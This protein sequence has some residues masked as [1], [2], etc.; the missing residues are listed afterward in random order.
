MEERSGISFL[1]FHEELDSAKLKHNSK[2]MLRARFDSTET[3]FGTM[4]RLA[5][6]LC[7]YDMQICEMFH[8][9]YF[10]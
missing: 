5:W 6:L 1:K 4:Q 2:H 8:I 7:R 10:K 3:K 9:F